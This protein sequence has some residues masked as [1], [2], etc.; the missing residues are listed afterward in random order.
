LNQLLLFFSLGIAPAAL[1]VA[2]IATS[3]DGMKTA[4]P[5][6]LALYVGAGLF[7]GVSVWRLPRITP[8]RLH[9]PLLFLLGAAARIP[10]YL[11]A[12]AHSDDVYRYLWEGRVQAASLSPYLEAPDSAKLLPLRDEAWRHINNRHLVTIYPPLAQLTFRLAAAL[13][14]SPIHAWKVLVAWADLAAALLLLAWLAQRGS[15]RRAV[16]AW[17]LS[18]LVIIE[19]GCEGHVDGIAIPLF[20]AALSA[21]ERGR[22]S[23]FGLWLGAASA[24]KFLPLY[25][26]PFLRR[27]AIVVCLASVVLVSLPYADAGPQLIG[28]LGEF[29]RRWRSNDGAFALLH[30]A[31][32]PV[33]QRLCSEGRFTF[34]R[35]SKWARLFSGRDR[36]E[37]YPD[38]VA[39]A[40]A[41]TI[42]LLLWLGLVAV[43]LN[44][45][46]SP[47]RL[48]EVVL[49]GFLL[50]TPTLHPWYAL[51]AVSLV[52]IGGSPALSMLAALVPLGYVPLSEWRSH[53]RWH[54]PIWSRV[55]EHGPVWLLVSAKVWPRIQIRVPFFRRE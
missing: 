31:C 1:T 48:S 4:H 23:L 46:Y 7:W 35:N 19:L 38:E 3:G 44:R 27:R 41:R 16:V 50:L 37:V 17:L 33:S 45:S 24:I 2:A 42:T 43:G 18:P 13:P 47:L 55:L 34:E 10:A 32:V 29:G 9:L 53:G 11:H 40:L 20:I 28:S 30:A 54:D 26:A 12:P 6:H 22:Q 39:A 51:W 14:L 5:L 15:D 25:L 21:L 49:G 8:H 36:D 52:A